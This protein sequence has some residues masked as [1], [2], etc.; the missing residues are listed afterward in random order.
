MTTEQL[1]Q[2]ARETAT[3]NGCSDACAK[4]ILSA[5]RTADAAAVE[6]TRQEDIEAIEKLRSSGENK[7]DWT[8]TRDMAFHA[9]KAA[10]ESLAANEPTKP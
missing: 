7:D 9:A 8:I 10:L 6:R 5:L 4:F 3:K 2:L 1:E